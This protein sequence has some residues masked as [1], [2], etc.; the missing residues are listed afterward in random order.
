MHKETIPSSTEAF[1]K[2]LSE[3]KTVDREGN[4]LRKEAGTAEHGPEQEPP[5]MEPLFPDHPQNNDRPYECGNVVET[6]MEQFF[7]RRD[8]FLQE[9]PDPFIVVSW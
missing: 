1:L 9:G 8:V 2:N 4:G 6:E 7:L 5:I 3:M